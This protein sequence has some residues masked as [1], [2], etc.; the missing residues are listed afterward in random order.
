[1]L[2]GLIGKKKDGQPSSP[3]PSAP[4]VK[5]SKKG[6][7]VK[8]LIIL[9]ILSLVSYGLY[10]YVENVKAKA[11]VRGGDDAVSMIRE[12]ALDGGGVEIE[13]EGQVITLSR[14]YKP[15]GEAIVNDDEEVVVTTTETTTEENTS[16]ENESSVVTPITPAVVTY[17]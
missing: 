9:V 7:I 16:E 3:R 12:A 13:M 10:L 17:T 8:S 2:F 14:Y 15:I 4:T 5:K 11:Y 1:M 6:L